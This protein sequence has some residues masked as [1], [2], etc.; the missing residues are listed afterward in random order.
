MITLFGCGPGFDLPEASPY[1]TKTEVQL[2]MAGLAYRKETAMPDASPKGQLPFIGD[3]GSLVADSTFIRA[4]IERKYGV[5]LDAGLDRASRAQ[6]WAIERMLE[7]H[8]GWVFVNY[9]WLVPGNFARGPAHFFDGAPAHLQDQLRQQAVAK[10]TERVLAIGITRHRPEEI[11]E[12][13]GRTLEALSALLDG[14][15]FLFGPRPSAADATA[16]AFLAGALSPFFDQPLRARAERLPNLVAYTNR[17]MAR[18]YPE[19]DWAAARAARRE[20]EFA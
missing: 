14:Q 1:V 6:S 17:M 13:G 19:F 10:V 20:P 11:A 9:R 15:D 2:R 16:F 3:D 18:F 8:F 12:L 5:D 7:N 4:H